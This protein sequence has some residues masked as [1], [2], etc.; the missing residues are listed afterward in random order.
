MEKLNA[1]KHYL[2]YPSGNY[3]PFLAYGFRPIFLVLIPYIVLNIILWAM[4]WTGVLPLSFLKDPIT[5]HIYELLFGVGSAGIMAFLLTGLPELFPGVVPLVGRKLAYLVSVWILGRITFWFLDFINIYIVGF[6]NI[7]PLLFMIYYAFKPAVLDAAQKHSSIAYNVVILSILQI[8]FF[9]SE[10]K[11]IKF[12]SRDIL[13]LSI[14]A[15]MS[16]IMLALR[17]VNTE[18]I[19][20]WLEIRNIDD[21]LIVKPP[22]YNLAIFCIVLFSI[23]QFFYPENTAIGWLGLATSASILGTLSEYKMENSIIIFE[24]YVLYLG[25]IIVMMALGYGFIGYS[26]F[27]DNFNHVNSFNHFLT[28]GAFGIAFFMVFVIVT[29]VH[30]GRA[31]KANFVVNFGIISLIISTIL[32]VLVGFYPQ[33]SILFYTLSSICWI[34]AFGGYYIY[35]YKFLLTPRAD[36]IKG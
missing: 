29:F 8:S 27:D 19:N 12:E 22:R 20:E 23:C 3:S 28:I 2:H 1:T 13:N 15:F 30:T 16:L 36:G 18:A 35:F 5:W 21:I 34:L 17:R 7:L 32:R 14:G 10:A 11:I 25:S 33:F 26:F 6:I 31:L 9:L 4:F 24:P